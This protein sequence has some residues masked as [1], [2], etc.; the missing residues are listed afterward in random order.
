MSPLVYSS[1]D[2]E[3]VPLA[4]KKALLEG[5]ISEVFDRARMTRAKGR[6]LRDAHSVAWLCRFLGQA[7]SPCED[8]VIWGNRDPLRCIYSRVLDV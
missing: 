1:S 4:Q 6:R 2:D 8:G 3:D 5:R 7:G